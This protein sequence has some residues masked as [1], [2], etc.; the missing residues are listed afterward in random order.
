MAEV[1]GGAGGFPE[2]HM[3]IGGTALTMRNTPA[4]LGAFRE[5]VRMDPQREEAWVMLARITAATK[6]GRGHQGRSGPSPCR[7]PRERRVDP[8]EGQH[9][10]LAVES[11]EVVHIQP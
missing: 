10:A 9:R 5:A 3:V 1:A 2:T 7:Q 11:H 6:G 4:A 8:D